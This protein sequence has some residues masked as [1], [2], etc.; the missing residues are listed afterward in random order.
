V[1]WWSTRRDTSAI[2]LYSEHLKRAE[3][4]GS[5]VDPYWHVATEAYLAL[6]RADTTKAM[7][8]LQT[9]PVPVGQVWYE[10]L[11]LARLMAAKGRDR[12][13]FTVLD[14]GFPWAYQTLERVPWALERARLA[15]K[16]G[17][18]DTARYWYAYVARVWQHADPDFL[19]PVR[20]ARE[21]LGRLTSEG[22]Q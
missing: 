8:L 5:R 17:E 12:E 19:A 10:R 9:L 22:T 14:A 1:P 6:A 7:R 11:T 2:K 4:A 21:A 3:K 13:A 15:E 20:E 18:N 16:L